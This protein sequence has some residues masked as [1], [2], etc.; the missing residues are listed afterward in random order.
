[1]I[2]N[3][4]DRP[5]GR[6]VTRS[7]LEWEV[8]SSNLGP[9]KS[10]IVDNGSPPQRHF[11]ARSCV[12][13]RNDAKMGSANSLHASAYCSEYSERFYWMI[14]AFQASTFVVELEITRSGH[15]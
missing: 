2:T 15:K 1:M 5:V 14:I 12:A 13:G 7:F 8:G 9:V 3:V 6:T 4:T 10:D 11:F